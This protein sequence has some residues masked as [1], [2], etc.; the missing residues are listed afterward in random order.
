MFDLE[1]RIKGFNGDLISPSR[2]CL[3][4]FDAIIFSSELFIL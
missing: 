4:E 1:D 2:M 3:K